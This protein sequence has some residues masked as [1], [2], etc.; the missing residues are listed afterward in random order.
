MLNSLQNL[1]LLNELV[2]FRNLLYGLT[3]RS[4]SYA[5]TGTAGGVFWVYIKPL[6]VIA[7]Y[8]FVFDKVLSIRLASDSSGTSNYSLFLLSGIL[9]W[10]VFS[11]AIS[12]GVSSLVK[13]A[14]LL[15]KTKFP[16][17]LIPARSVLSSS[18]K[19]Y[20]F[21]LLLQPVG[22][23][24][25]DGSWIA[26]PY[27]VVWAALQLMLTY[28][29]VTLFSILCAALR[30][31]GMLI[32]TIF[33]VL[34]F[35]SP[36]LYPIERVPEIF[37]WLLHLNPFTPFANGYHAILLQGQFPSL[38]DVLSIMVWIGASLL[39]CHLLLKRSREYLIDW[40]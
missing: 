37:V 24:F 29:L 17:E 23:Y 13:E 11:E 34:L 31:V 35:I 12:E 15:K 20:P 40:L 26:L 14:D 32:E 5:Y 30:D 9:P 10:L 16:L 1:F 36:V 25:A 2:R 33:P 19:V 27:L 3:S 8:Y 39:L 22:V 6:I 4:L 7:A 18:I 28:Y 21:I 38:P